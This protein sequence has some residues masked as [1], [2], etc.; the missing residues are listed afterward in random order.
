M[1]L[2]IK[3]YSQKLIRGIVTDSNYN[4][5]SSASILIKSKESNI[6]KTF[7]FTNSLGK[8]TISIPVNII[9]DSNILIVTHVN[10]KQY[11]CPTATLSDNLK[12]ILAE[13]QAALNEVIVKSSRK[14][15]SG[16]DTTAYNVAAFQRPEDYS[17]GDV[18]RR[19][20]GMIVLDDGTIEFNGR[21]ISKFLIHGD[22]L[23][24]GKYGLGSRSINKELIK[25][26]EVI[27]NHQ[28]IYLLQNKVQ[29]ND[30]AINLVLNNENSIKLSGKGEGGVGLPNLAHVNLTG[31]LFNKKHKVLSNTT[32]NNTGENIKIDFKD[33]TNEIKFHPD[34]I[35]SDAIIEPTELPLR[36]YYFNSTIGNS[37]NYLFT[38]KDSIQYKF[39][40][41]YYSDRNKLDFNLSS[42]FINILDTITY[43][44]FQNNIRHG[45]FIK[46]SLSTT[47][48]TSK[49]FWSNNFSYLKQL[50]QVNNNLNFNSIKII[51]NLESNEEKYENKFSY[52]PNLK[53]SD[54]IKLQVITSYQSRP[55][56][57]NINP[58]IEPNIFND[59]IEYISLKQKI[60]IKSFFNDASLSWILNNQSRIQQS[61]QVGL[62]NSHDILLTNI[63]LTQLD[64]TPSNFLRDQGNSLNFRKSIQYVSANYAVKSENL[65]LHL[66][67][68]VFNQSVNLEHSLYQTSTK[69]NFIYL[70]PKLSGEYY[71][72]PQSS[73]QFNINTNNEFGVLQNIYEGLVVQN[74]KTFRRNQPFI[75]QR[76]SQNIDIR[77]NAK[78]ADKMLFF[79][80]SFNFTQARLNSVSTIEVADNFISN[81]F[82]PLDN[83]QRVI[84]NS[85]GLSKYFFNIKTKINFK[86]NFSTAQL[87]QFVNNILIPF[88][89]N[90]ISLNLEIEKR[91]ADYFSLNFSR[92]HI[93]TKSFQRANSNRYQLINQVVQVQNKI[94]FLY[95]PPKIPF[96]FSIETNLQSNR[97][98]KNDLNNFA[99]TD[100]KIAHKTKK[101]NLSIDCYNILNVRNYNTFFTEN[102]LTAISSFPLRGRMLLLKFGYIF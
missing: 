51:Q 21:K 64:S 40:I 85:N 42:I 59:S 33:L 7:A 30:I 16:G 91:F 60:N 8:F 89:R 15:I 88:S 77:Y 31:I 96:Y 90:Q 36:N 49:T 69:E 41:D 10:Y 81:I 82:I 76:R 86:S 1:I 35:L 44:E 75:N 39:N 94:N 52:I 22:D 46:G 54:L 95:S 53:I 34:K 32:F 9:N 58:G 83:T 25:K 74:Y 79:F 78:K 102:N 66:Y 5:I 55:E 70:N 6:I 24:G 2:P 68:P 17:I 63:I 65:R 48:N 23:L 92:A 38:S 13:K 29:T 3:N 100:L 80:S 87:N 99:F 45:N 57:L 4:P 47:K 61:Y 72:G 62:K 37:L 11:S 93:Y 50:S 43:T 84:S 98:D 26:I 56:Q 101:Y 71:F 28:P 67:L 14:I 27:E 19:L 18:I 12:I 20:P 97:I 73:L